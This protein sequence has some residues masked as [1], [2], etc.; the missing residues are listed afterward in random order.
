MKTTFFSESWYLWRVFTDEISK[1]HYINV[2]GTYIHVVLYTSML[3]AM[4]S[5]QRDTRKRC[6]T[7]LKD[8][9]AEMITT[10]R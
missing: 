3:F 2:M 1:Y 8:E 7:K 4:S 10:E 6:S 5:M 9:E